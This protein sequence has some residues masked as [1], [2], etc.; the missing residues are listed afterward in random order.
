MRYKLALILW[1]LVCSLATLTSAPLP[2]AHD[3]EISAT[4][5]S[6][7]WAMHWG[8]ILQDATFYTDA[9]YSRIYGGGD[10]QIDGKN[11]ACRV[12]FNERTCRYVMEIRRGPANKDGPTFVGRGWRVSDDGTRSGEIEVILHRPEIQ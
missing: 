6:G 2:K 5:L 7:E 3:A 12:W 4:D 10:Y 8:M 1:S 9:Y 11:S